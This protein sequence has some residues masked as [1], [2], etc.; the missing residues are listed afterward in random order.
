M[1]KKDDSKPSAI[2]VPSERKLKQLA[3]Q[4]NTAKEKTS[5]IGGEIGQA[6]R[7]MAEKDGL[8]PGAFRAAMALLRKDGPI[9]RNHLDHFE[10][11]CEVLGVYKKAEDSPPL[12]LEEGD[13]DEKDEDDGKVHRLVSAAE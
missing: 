13:D 9:L 1:A 3:A 2:K 12:E 5:G 8:H 10:H 11:Y 7:S 4:Y 6:I